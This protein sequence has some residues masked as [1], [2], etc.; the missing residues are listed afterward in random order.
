MRTLLL[1][2][3]VV[4]TGACF[5]GHLFHECRPVCQDPANASNTVTSDVT[6]KIDND[7]QD[8]S[9]AACV[10]KAATTPDVCMPGW[11]VV[12]CTCELRED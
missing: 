8:E 1:L 3:V 5:G 7:S 4:G 12:R 9:E 2:A 10:D 11:T 6:L